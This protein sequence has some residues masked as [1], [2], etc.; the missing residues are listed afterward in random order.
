MA[1]HSEEI[2]VEKKTSLGE[3]DIAAYERADIMA[4]LGEFD[5]ATSPDFLLNKIGTHIAVKENMMASDED[6][7]P[8][9]EIVAQVSYV[10]FTPAEY[11]RQC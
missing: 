7:L 11:I 8:E 9:R 4:V 2:F 6:K 1:A 10:I 5:P 3:D